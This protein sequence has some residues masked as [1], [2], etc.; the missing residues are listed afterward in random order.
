MSVIWATGRQPA[1]H[2]PDRCRRQAMAVAWAQALK[3]LG[4]HMRPAVLHRHHHG[5]RLGTGRCAW[6]DRCWRCADRPEAPAQFVF[7]RG[8]LARKIRP[9]KACW[10]SSSA[11]G[12]RDTLE[13]AVLRQAREQ[14]GAGGLQPILTVVE[15]RATF[16]CMPGLRRPGAQ[17]A[18]GLQAA[19]DFLE[20]PYPATLEAAVRAGVTAG[21]QVRARVD[22]DRGQSL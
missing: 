8:Q 12:D 11:Q 15:K 13:Q 9:C 4:R 16:A 19:G 6:A 22:N 3:R 10:P 7:D 21:A 14:L 20:G 5:L 1:G 17:L 2:A 18:P